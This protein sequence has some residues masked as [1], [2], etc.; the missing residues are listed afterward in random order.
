MS[1]DDLHGIKSNGSSNGL[2]TGG[3]SN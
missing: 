1:D 2:N 3:G